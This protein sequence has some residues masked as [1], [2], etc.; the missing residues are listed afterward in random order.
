MNEAG[1]LDGRFVTDVIH[2]YLGDEEPRL[3]RLA[4]ILEKGPN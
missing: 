4:E 1:T 3:A 2:Q